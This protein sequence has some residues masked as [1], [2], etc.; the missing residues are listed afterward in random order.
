MRNASKT[1][2]AALPHELRALEVKARRGG[3][4]TKSEREIL[5]KALQEREADINALRES[6]ME[7]ARVV[8]DSLRKQG[9]YAKA[10]TLDAVL[11]EVGEKQ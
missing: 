8:A 10:D 2:A 6:V 5:E 3:M 9:Q 1:G 11:E 4:L 7:K